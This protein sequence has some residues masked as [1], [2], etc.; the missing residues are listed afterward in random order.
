MNFLV[1]LTTQSSPSRTA[2]VWMP[3]RSEPVPGSVIA[4]PSTVSP[5]TTPG[6]QRAF[7]SSVP[8]STM[9]GAMMSLTRLGPTIA[10]NTRARVAS[11]V[12]MRL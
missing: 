7:C 4:I 12:R 10:G 5:A 11:S 8:M 6:S 3:A 9:Y 1:P 2:V